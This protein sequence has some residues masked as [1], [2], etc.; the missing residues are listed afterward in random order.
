MGQLYFVVCSEG[1]VKVAGGTFHVVVAG[2]VLEECHKYEETQLVTLITPSYTLLHLRHAGDRKVGGVVAI[3]RPAIVPPNSGW[4][5]GPKCS[6]HMC[7]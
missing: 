7:C 3:V 4:F 6:N 5:S 2:N 1:K